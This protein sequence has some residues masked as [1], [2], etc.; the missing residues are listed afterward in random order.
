MRW[1]WRIRMHV[2]YLVII[3]SNL[4][5]NERRTDSREKCVH[6]CCAKSYISVYFEINIFLIS[7]SCPLSICFICCITTLVS[8]HHSILEIGPVIPRKES[9]HCHY[10]TAKCRAFFRTEDSLKMIA[11]GQDDEVTSQ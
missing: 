1:L 9:Q 6:L 11:A 10:S 8:S 7:S 5:T 2:I 4:M 3:Y